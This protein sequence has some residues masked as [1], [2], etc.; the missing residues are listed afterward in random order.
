MP[1]V[2]NLWRGLQGLW[3]QRGGCSPPEGSEGLGIE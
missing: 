2:L 1:G 3:E